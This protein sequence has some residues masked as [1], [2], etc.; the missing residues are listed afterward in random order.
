MYLQ[1]L[2][3]IETFLQR[4]KRPLWILLG[5][6]A[7]IGIAANVYHLVVLVFLQRIEDPAPPI[8]WEMGR[9]ILN[10]LI[11]YED[12]YETKPPG[13]FVLSA[14]SLKLFGRPILGNIIHTT[15]LFSIPLLFVLQARRLTLSL[16]RWHQSALMALA[17]LGSSTLLRY[18]LPAPSGWLLDFHGAAFGILYLLAIADPTKLTKVRLVLATI[19]LFVSIGLKETFILSAL[20]GALV[21]LHGRREFLR[22]WVLPA[23]CAAFGGFLAL[24]LTGW[25]HAFFS[26]YLPSMLG[27]YVQRFPL[28]WY[29]RGFAFDQVFQNLST[30]S[31][32]LD[33]LVLSLLALPFLQ[34]EK[35]AGE[36]YAAAT[37]LLLFL[38]LS[39]LLSLTA[40][41]L[42]FKT[43]RWILGAFLLFSFLFLPFYVRDWKSCAVPVAFIV[44]AGTLL[45]TSFQWC[46]STSAT[47]RLLSTLLPHSPG[48]NAPCIG[49]PVLSLLF[50]FAPLP[51]LMRSSFPRKL[52][53]L[54]FA[55]SLL[56]AAIALLYLGI[57]LQILR[58]PLPRTI[59]PSALLVLA[60]SVGVLFF[61]W[62]T[63][64]RRAVWNAVTVFGAL[65]LTISAVAMAG[66][67][68]NQHFMS[69]V[70]LYTA[71]FLAALRFI[72]QHFDRSLSFFALLLLTTLSTFISLS[73]YKDYSLLS[74][75]KYK[76]NIAAT[77]SVTTLAQESAAHLDAILDRCSV[78][79]YYI[80]K[81]G[82]SDF[83]P[84][85]GYTLHSPLNFFYW[86]GLEDIIRYHPLV[87][88]REIRNFNQAKI[89]IAG[90]QPYEPTKPFEQKIKAFLDQ[91]FTTE[92]WPCAVGL[93]TPE[94]RTMLYRRLKDVHAPVRSG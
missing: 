82:E 2:M 65:F 80:V 83:N 76:A 35:S 89:V 32:A 55:A 62:Q 61:Q 69:A 56:L 93:P 45:L 12:I 88:E 31:P 13:I 57:I 67:F 19:A 78:D 9:A 85:Y 4:Y 90:D 44:A 91:E 74:P 37:S 54:L 25:L 72:S 1:W 6:T 84:F 36:R 53:F 48:S 64:Q 94:K 14:L 59:L 71:A 39:F 34:K 43:S 28:P 41:G 50:A 63:E 52:R 16:S 49:S 38:S 22:G 17:F 75:R 33:L 68:Q 46:T 18:L 42:T 66:D 47:F 11:P 92:P 10:G 15:L 3:W 51:L 7:A 73:P 40:P 24:A 27:G 30:L 79:R 21:L 29:Q 8:Y 87:A 86:A 70:P 26:V 58:L 20:A 60:G 77:H 5:C 81:L 23:A